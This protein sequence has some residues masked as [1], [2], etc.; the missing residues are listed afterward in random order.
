M[1]GKSLLSGIIA[2][3]LIASA[4]ALLTTP[5][6]GK[7]LRQNCKVTTSRWQ[8]DLAQIATDSKAASVQL[9]TTA[10]LSKDAFDSVGEEVKKSVDHWRSDVEPT[11]TK[12]KED[13]E[14]LQKKCRTIK[15]GT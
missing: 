4:A 3:S 14:A 15:E 11:L 7:K 2:G 9:K 13:I 5:A 1:N 6:S 10:K 12:L 8:K